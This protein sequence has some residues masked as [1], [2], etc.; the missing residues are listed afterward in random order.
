MRTWKLLGLGLLL[1]TV[2]VT[3]G[4]TQAGGRMHGE[5]LGFG[6][7]LRA[8]NLT[9][10]QHAQ[11]HDAFATYRTTVQPLWPQLRMARQQLTDALVS[12][13]PLDTSGLNTATQQLGS[14]HNQLLQARVTLA[15]AIRDILTPEQLTQAAQLKDQLRS[16]QTTRHQLLAPQ[17]QP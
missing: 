15:E 5:V 9:E 2:W 10:S 16:L 17:A 14:L 6:P 12:P 13:N 8:L 7:L 3:P 11:V 1:A 4:W